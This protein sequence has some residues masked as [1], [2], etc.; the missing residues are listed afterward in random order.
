M[1]DHP[2]FDADLPEDF[3]DSFRATLCRA[4][5]GSCEC[6]ED[7]EVVHRLNRPELIRDPDDRI[8]CRGEGLDPTLDIEVTTIPEDVT[9][10]SCTEQMK[11]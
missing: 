1:A 7:A 6:A 10:K 5:N 11:A 3:F 4:V 2:D 8:L 9:C